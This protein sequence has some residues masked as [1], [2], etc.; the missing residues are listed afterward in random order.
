MLPHQIGFLPGVED[1][2][3]WRGR[4]EEGGP[5]PWARPRDGG[6]DGGIYGDITERKQA[7]ETLRRSEAYLTEGQRLSHAGSWARNVSTGD[8][9]F[10]EESFR[11]FGFDPE[12][13]KMTLALLLNWVHPDDRPSRCGRKLMKPRCSMRSSEKVTPSIKC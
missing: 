11:I 3:R 9:F 5:Q 8:I 2:C 4:D 13:T 12:K 1:Y 10:S 6:L 7:E